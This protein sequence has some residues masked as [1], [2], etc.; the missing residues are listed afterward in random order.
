MFFNSSKEEI[1]KTIIDS[2]NN[3]KFE[4]KENIKLIESEYLF[5]I[6]SEPYKDFNYYIGYVIILNRTEY[7]NGEQKNYFDDSNNINDDKKNYKGLMK[8]KFKED[9]TIYERL[10]K[11]DLNEIFMNEINDTI[12]CLI[13]KF[14][15]KR[16][17]DQF[18]GDFTIDFGDDKNKNSFWVSN[19]MNGSLC[20]DDDILENSKYDSNINFTIQ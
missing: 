7:L 1:I 6:V 12:S 5:A 19:T 9:G 17:L 2:N 20:F 16:N 13:P 10:Y 11:E 18:D 14:L 3:N 15:N 4:E 8:V